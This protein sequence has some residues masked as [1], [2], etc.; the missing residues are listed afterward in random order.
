MSLRRRR[1]EKRREALARLKIHPRDQ[2]ENRALLAKAERMYEECLGGM[3]DYIGQCIGVFNVALE[4]QD[5]HVIAR[6]RKELEERLAR[7]D[8]GVLE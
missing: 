4:S 1:T 5:E 2:A 8:L 6:A 3:R 7:V